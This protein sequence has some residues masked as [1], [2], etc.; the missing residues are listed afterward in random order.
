MADHTLAFAIYIRACPV[1]G[2]P[3]NALKLLQN[4]LRSERTTKKT[5]QTFFAPE[6]CEIFRVTDQESQ[7]YRDFVTRVCLAI[8]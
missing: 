2:N 1:Q 5:N 3:S 8:I 4:G 6:T 7:L